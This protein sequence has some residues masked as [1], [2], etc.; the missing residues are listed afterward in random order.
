MAKY[1]TSNILVNFRKN[2]IINGD[3]RIYQRD[4]SKSVSTGGYY[5]LDRW[6][7]TVDA[8]D[9]AVIQWSVDTESPSGFGASMQIDCTTAESVVGDSEY[10]VIEQRIEAQDCQLLRWGGVGAQAVT[11]SFYLKSITKTG[12]MGIAI[13][14]ADSDYTMIKEITISDANWNKYELTFPG[15]RGGSGIND[16]N[17][18]GLRVGFCLFAGVDHQDTADIW[19]SLGGGDTKWATSNQ[20]NFLDH[21]DNDLY[22]TGVQLEIGEEATGFEIRP[23][24][25]EVE[26]CQRYFEKT[27]R[28]EV[29]AGSAVD[30]GFHTLVD[31]RT[32]NQ[33]DAGSVRFKVWKRAS[34]TYTPYSPDS[35]TADKC[36]NL[37]TTTDDAA[38]G[39]AVGAG[40]VAHLSDTGANSIGDRLLW[41]YTADAEL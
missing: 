38:N 32:G 3:M 29:P 17:G 7:Y 26:M 14:A 12:V 16:D 13:N 19:H 11:L 28:I 2:F 33:Q 6:R 30:T 39:N 25:T 40:G 5:T 23:M 41:H 9:D 1:S 15:L 20:A 27:W 34:P 31:N 22:I 8:I 36:Y 18:I 10:A 21:S 4:N 24:G 35:G 37:T